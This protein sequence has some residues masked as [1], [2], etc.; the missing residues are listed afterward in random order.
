MNANK[1]EIRKAVET[2]FS[3][4][5]VDVNTLII[6]GHMKRMGRGYSKTKNW[7]K[8]IVTLKDGDSIAVPVFRKDGS[9]AAALSAVLPL[10]LMD[11]EAVSAQLQ[12][13]L[14]SAPTTSPSLSGTGTARVVLLDPARHGAQRLEIDSGLVR[15]RVAP[16]LEE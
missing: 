11:D 1:I 16:D 8:A 7:K 9:V 15:L 10:Q 6:R 12:R 5:V 3:V 4:S 14:P 13:A 2:L